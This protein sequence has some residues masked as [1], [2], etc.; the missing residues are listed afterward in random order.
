[1][2]DKLTI[3]DNSNKYRIL[4]AF[5]RASNIRIAIIDERNETGESI[6]LSKE[7]VIELRNFLNE[8]IE[9]QNI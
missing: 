4:R 3:I 5:P 7:Q 2:S 8:F 9:E 1:M 6:P